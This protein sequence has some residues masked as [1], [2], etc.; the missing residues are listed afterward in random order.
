MKLILMGVVLGT[1][2]LMVCSCASVPTEPLSP[3]EIRLLAM[4]FSDASEVRKEQRYT[5][6]VKFDAQGA[7]EITRACFQWSGYGSN[8]MKPLDYGNGLIKAEILAPSVPGSY[9]IKTYIYYVRNGK[10]EQS[11][12]VT[13][14][15]AVKGEKKPMR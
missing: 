7:P 12:A 5:V 9:S 8:C 11:N 1:I 14:P 6:D 4:D 13:T 15:V 3:G 2:V 10:M